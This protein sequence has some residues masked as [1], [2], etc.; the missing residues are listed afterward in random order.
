G[1]FVTDWRD[2]HPD[3]ARWLFA[4]G[5]RWAA[6][7]GHEGELDPEPYGV[8]NKVVVQATRDAGLEPIMW[9]SISAD[10]PEKRPVQSAL[11]AARARAAIGANAY[12]ANIE[13]PYDDRTFLKQWR[14]VLPAMTTWLSC[15]ITNQRDWPAWF[16]KG[17]IVPGYPVA[18][19]WLPQ[20]YLNVNSSARPLEADNRALHQ[21]GIPLGV[22]KP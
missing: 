13:I 16:A 2:F 1:V 17:A 10:N 18:T 9:G 6:F 15:G 3:F 11:N 8:V 5:Y 12:I 19:A 4:L 7:H 20:C 21:Y 22:V 14:L